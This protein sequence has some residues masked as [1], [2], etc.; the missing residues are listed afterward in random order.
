M[1]HDADTGSGTSSPFLV[2]RP[3]DNS[4]VVRQVD[5]RSHRDIGW[6]LVCVMLVVAGAA[7]YAWPH[8]QLRQTGVA[9]E[10][11]A[12][13]RDRLVE[14]NR[15]LRLEKAS[16]ESLRRVETI[17]TRDL[18]LRQPR[19]EDTLIIEGPPP[20]PPANQVAAAASDASPAAIPG[21]P[22]ES[23]QVRDR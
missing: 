5:P 11:A 8:L 13:E 16:L 9:T 3:V 17:A 23:G 18:G 14:E 6:L 1:R 10:Q 12:R 4:G 21:R 22:A 7:L 19:P 2:G 20:S 15:K